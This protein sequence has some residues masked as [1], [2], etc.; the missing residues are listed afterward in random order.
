MN[1]TVTA[2][3]IGRVPERMWHRCG[4]NRIQPA[5]TVTSR[6]GDAWTDPILPHE[7]QLVFARMRVWTTRM[8]GPSSPASTGNRPSVCSDRMTQRTALP[9]IG[10]PSCGRITSRLVAISR[11]S[12]RRASRP[13]AGLRAGA[14]GAAGAESRRPSGCPS[15]TAPAWPRGLRTPTPSRSTGTGAE[16]LANRHHRLA[17][18]GTARGPSGLA[19]AS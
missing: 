8:R 19:Q 13:R 9:A 10:S 18:V 12:A 16:P 14:L 15:G 4:G 17:V 5:S 11:T 7:A 2:R 3:F 1:A 6:F